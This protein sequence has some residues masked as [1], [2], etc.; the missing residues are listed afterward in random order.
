MRRRIRDKRDR[1]RQLRVFCEVARLSSVT[2]A[3]ERLDL[4]QPAVSIQV[5][6]L[7]RELEAVL[8]ERDAMG[9]TLSAAGECL[10]ALAAP[11][12]RGVDGLYGGS[13]HRFDAESGGRVRLAATSAVADFVLPRY[14]KRF[15][16][17]HP[18]AAV[19]LDTATFSEGLERL[20]DE[21][22][23]LMLG[24]H[25]PYPQERVEYHELGTY[26]LVL[27][28]PLDHPLAGRESVS[29]Q[30]VRAYRSVVAP[31]DTYSLRSGETAVS[32]FGIEDNAV[33]EVGGWALI[34][35]YVEAGIGISVI[36]SLCVTASDRLSVTPLDAYFPPRNY[37]VFVLHDRVLTPQ[38]RRMFSVLLPDAVEPPHSRGGRG[39]TSQ[40]MMIDPGSESDASP[41]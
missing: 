14:L 41:T 2:R 38:A 40:P 12:V 11:L 21:K 15:H 30:D 34:K 7:E 32:A 1:I 4:T 35:R 39:G 6:E 27:I 13:H 20:L 9:V 29:P 10:Y 24:I 5:R 26:G 31:A 19:R 23:D 33:V 3:A 25:D 36:P 16:D 37:G 22:V 8:L 18:D 28:T 17:H